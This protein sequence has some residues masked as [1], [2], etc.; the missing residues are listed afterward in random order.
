MSWQHYG[1]DPARPGAREAVTLASDADRDAA[2]RV[3]N[4]AFAEGRLTADEHGERVRAAYA[5]RAWRELAW[6]TADLP[7]PAGSSG[8][9]D[10][11]GW[12]VA[13]A[14]G[15]LDRCLL[16]A[17]LILCPP[18]GITWLLAARHRSGAGRRHAV[19]TDGGLSVSAAPGAARAGD[20]WRAEDR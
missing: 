4:Q 12:A 14:P 13:G 2:V 5:A 20:G 17:L 11:A 8:A 3:L 19:T 16:C 10:T 7:G 15:G 6:L 18:A 9:A 1:R